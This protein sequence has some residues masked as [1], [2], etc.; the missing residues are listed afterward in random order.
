MRIILSS[1]CL[2]LV[3]LAL[4]LQLYGYIFVSDKTMNEI[5]AWMIF[6]F[7]ATITALVLLLTPLS[8]FRRFRP[9]LQPGFALAAAVLFICLL[10][11]S[12]IYLHHTWGGFWVVVGLFFM[13]F[14]CIPLG[15][16]AALLTGDWLMFI[17][18]LIC[19][20][21]LVGSSYAAWQ[22]AEERDEPKSKAVE[23]PPGY[24][25]DATQAVWISLCFLLPYG[26]YSTGKPYWPWVI[27]VIVIIALGLGNSRRWA[28]VAYLALAGA[29]LW[30]LYAKPELLVL[31]PDFRT[32]DASKEFHQLINGFSS[33]LTLALKIN[34]GIQHAVVV[35]AAGLL[36]TPSAIRWFWSPRLQVDEAGQDARKDGEVIDENEP[37]RD[38]GRQLELPLD[39]KE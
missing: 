1:A 6:P 33:Y 35:Y 28:Y 22:M 23:A 37:P 10:W 19:L 16:L 29:Y 14:G 26:I 17:L 18:F 11:V 38:E 27:P 13:V 21:G 20:T 25:R 7:S 36:L 2:I 15:I 32:L 30:L 24:A 39:D 9:L 34:S 8:A 3:V 5:A 31:R 12:T 4:V